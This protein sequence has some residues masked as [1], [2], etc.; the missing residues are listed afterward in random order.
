MSFVILLMTSWK[1]SFESA[2][3]AMPIGQISNIGIRYLRS[4]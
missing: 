4:P 3:L 1:L 2:M